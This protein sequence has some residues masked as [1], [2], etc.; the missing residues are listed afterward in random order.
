MKSKTP[1]VAE[2]LLKRFGIPQRNESLMGDLVEEYGA[3]RSALWFWRQTTVAIG[4]T[5]GRDIG[6]HKLLVLRAVATGWLLNVAWGKFWRLI[7]LLTQPPG[8]WSQ[9]TLV[10][11]QVLTVSLWPALVGWLV[12]RTHRAQQAAMVLAYFASMVIWTAGFFA[13]NYAAIKSVPDVNIA[14]AC[15]LACTL[16]GG[17]LQKPREHAAEPRAD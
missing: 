12:A 15:V 9:H 6:N 7:L 5:V 16:I 11:Y 8:M 1:A 3:G 13:V 17:F 10:I 4:T 2:W 14:L